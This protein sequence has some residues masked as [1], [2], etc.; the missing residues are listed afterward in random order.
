ME[1]NIKL[2]PRNGITIF[3]DEYS[4]TFLSPLSDYIDHLFVIYEDAYGDA[5]SGIMN[6]EM[7]MNF[8]DLDEKIIDKI[9]K[10]LGK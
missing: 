3:Q 9:F 7:M 4:L 2:I 1:E 8:Y 10:K 6:K 5:V